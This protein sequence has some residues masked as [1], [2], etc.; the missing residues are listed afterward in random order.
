MGNPGLVPLG[1]RC[2]ENPLPNLSGTNIEFLFRKVSLGSYG[3]AE[4]TAGTLTHG[5]DW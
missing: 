1:F 4:R 5:L 2:K 3:L